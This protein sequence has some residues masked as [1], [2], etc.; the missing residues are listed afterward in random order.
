MQTIVSS[1]A[2]MDSMF[3]DTDIENLLKSRGSAYIVVGP[4]RSGVGVM[5]KTL[6]KAGCEPDFMGDED[7][8][9]APNI[10]MSRVVNYDTKDNLS[11]IADILENRGY[12]VT[13]IVMLRSMYCMAASQFAQKMYPADCFGES[14]IKHSYHQIFL[15][16]NSARYEMISYEELVYQPKS[17]NLWLVDKGLKPALC[18]ER[19]LPNHNVKHL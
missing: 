9:H 16:I 10:V 1:S 13:F 5:V 8:F 15:Q 11:I 2:R 12:E 19:L 3:S 4:P 7:A 18:E 14:E 17:I 6:K